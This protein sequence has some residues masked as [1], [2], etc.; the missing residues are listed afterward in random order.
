MLYKTTRLA[1]L[2]VGLSLSCFAQQA[3]DPPFEVAQATG[4]FVHVSLS[5]KN[6]ILSL[7]EVQV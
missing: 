5:G 3:A 6:R 4:R 2:A 7:A 1:I